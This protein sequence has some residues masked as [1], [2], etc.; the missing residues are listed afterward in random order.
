MAELPAGSRAVGPGRATWIAIAIAAMFYAGLSYLHLAIL[1]PMAGGLQSPDMR[2]FGYGPETVTAW[3][4]ALG[5][6]GRALFLNYHTFMLDLF[7]PPAF[8]YALA[9]VT[10]FAGR[11]LPWHDRLAWPRRLVL[12]VLL[13]AFYLGFDWSEN[14]A[15]ARMV[16]DPETISATTVGVASLRTVW[17]WV[18]VMA[19]MLLPAGLY[20]WKRMVRDR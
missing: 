13:P 17:K 14:W 19:A 7:F 2:A 1:Q 11:G 15:V 9:L 10:N 3:V 8:A 16:A 5:N 18:F 4:N 6:E 20:T 12:A